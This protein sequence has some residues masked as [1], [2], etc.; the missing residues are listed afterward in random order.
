MFGD[1]FLSQRKNLRLITGFGGDGEEWEEWWIPLWKNKKHIMKAVR[2]G[3]W[4]TWLFKTL[5]LCCLMPYN[6]KINCPNC[7]NC[8]FRVKKQVW[9]CE[10][11]SNKRTFKALIFLL[12]NIWLEF[13]CPYISPIWQVVILLNKYPW[14][15]Q[16]FPMV[17]IS[18]S[19]Y[20]F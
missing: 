9:V 1:L 3:G 5:I 2:E 10:E 7:S 18:V 11:L 12:S 8:N 19:P 13:R 17:W 20:I 15:C 6:K 4:H 16:S 14:M